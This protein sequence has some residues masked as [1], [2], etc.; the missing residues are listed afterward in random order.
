MEWFCKM[1]TRYSSIEKI[2]VFLKELS[3][4]YQHKMKDEFFPEF[5]AD[6]IKGSAAAIEV[7][8]KLRA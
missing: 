5:L 7:Y 8:L 4:N 3:Y 1:Y 2:F 6:F